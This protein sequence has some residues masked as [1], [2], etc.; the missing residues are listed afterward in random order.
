MSGSGKGLLG[1]WLYR[2]SEGW[3]IK[4]GSPIHKNHEIPMLET[5]NNSE[6]KN[7]VIFSLKNQVGG[8]ARALQV[9][10]DLGVN[11]V[12]I[13]SRKSLRR[14]SE[15][16][17]LVD[18]EC[19]SKRMEQLMKM[20]NREV[21][22]INLAQYEKTGNI[23]EQTPC[24][25]TATSFDYSEIDMP[26]F[27][28]KISDLD[29]AQK[30]LMYGSDLDADHPGFKDPVYRKRRQEF[31][32]IANN[33][34]YGQP[35]P[36]IQYTPEEIRT[37]GTVF[38]ELHQLYQKHA[39]M[40]YL[41]NWP[42]LVKYCGYREDNIPQLEDVNIFL[43]RT[44]GFQ[45]RPVAGYLS[46]R[47]FLA[48]LAFRVFHC[49]QYIRHSS[50]PF[51]TP[52]PDCCHELLGHMPLLANK[53]FAQFSQEIGLASLGASDNDID[54][55][56]TLY[57]FT[58]EFGLCKQ[59]GA[60][61]VYGA[62]LLSS[63]AELRHAV[64][65]PEKTFRFEPEV[66]CKQECI[67]TAFQN[68]YYYTNSIEEAKEKMR[69]FANEIQRPFGLRYNPYTQSVEVLTDAQK[70]TA[71]V[72]EL[73]GDLCIVSNALRK[74]HEQDDTVDVERITNLL[75]QGIDI[76]R[77]TSSSDSDDTDKSPN[78]DERQTNSPK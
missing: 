39:C 76:I 73:R 55:L 25:S 27:P 26:W 53:S 15:Y 29:Q 36:R 42:K 9:F 21:A 20:L 50:D 22:A 16:E 12:H 52:E 66:T 40:E 77:D 72:S 35:I 67:I 10:Q 63:V 59:D 3:Q 45:L 51:Y 56:A 43:K 4:E 32:D 33:Y 5:E 68:A 31:A 11:V 49:T 23:P 47:D 69:A 64:S 34:K 54:K 24:L 60:Y 6:N 71:V 65:A 46:P 37:W 28:R 18:V 70:I 48:G 62:G 2:K 17:I 78:A 7:S 57:F 38:R 14:G 74:I 75:T 13:E 8:L 44:T 30:V 61:R 58:V 41:E 19:D 1:M